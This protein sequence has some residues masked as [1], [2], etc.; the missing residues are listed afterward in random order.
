MKLHSL[1]AGVL[2]LGALAAQ[3]PANPDTKPPSAA[4]R[5]QELSDLQEKAVAD[6]RADIK[7]AKE[8]RDAGRE[9][10]RAMRMRPDFGP[11]AE[12]ALAYAKEFQGKDEAV[13]FLMMVVNLDQQRARPALETLLKDHIDS[14]KLSEMGRMIPYLD[15]I[16][17]PEFAE[18]ARAKLMKSKSVDVRGWAMFAAHQATI[19]KSD[20][21]GAA[22]KDA[23][24][25]LTAI[26]QEVT[27]KALAGEITGAINERE[28]FGIGCTAPDI[29]GLDLDGVAFKLSDYKGKVIFL[30]FWGDW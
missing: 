27:D 28:Q 21:N 14:P 1:L 4:E 18:E 6:W 7:K 8:D 9:S 17:S 16:V 12:K 20:L 19:E 29:E 25:K 10:A 26:A 11:V 3:D 24:S 13:D 22:Y 5:M 23:R 15:R 2:L 30:D